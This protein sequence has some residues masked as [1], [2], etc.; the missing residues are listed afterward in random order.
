MNCR[1]PITMGQRTNSAP[2]LT[3]PEYERR[4]AMLHESAPVMPTR[5]QE[6][7]TRRAELDLLIDYKLDNDFPQA[8]RDALW[9]EQV[10]LDNHLPW[11]LLMSCLTHPKSPSDGIAQSQIRAFA[12]VLEP[13]E[14]SALLDLTADDVLRLLK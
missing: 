8:R 2:R 6:L 10:R 9:K 13:D 5:T 7:A 14:L 11:R 3:R 12:K 1:Y 4:I